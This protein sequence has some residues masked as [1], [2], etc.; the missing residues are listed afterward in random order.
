MAGDPADEKPAA[1]ISFEHDENGE[2]AG[3]AARLGADV[4]A[5]FGPRDEAPLSIRALDG[6]GAL[7]GGLNG[8]THWRWLYVRHL[9]VT[10]GGRGAGLGRRLLAEAEA[11]ARRRG[12]VGIYLDTF[13]AGAAAFYERC[14]FA[15]HGVIEDFPPG[16]ARTYLSKKF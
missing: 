4:A 9:F 7:V 16:F 1:A 10:E 12:C 14:G 5:Q 6:S 11:M 15:R 8:V 2:D 13:D 3:V